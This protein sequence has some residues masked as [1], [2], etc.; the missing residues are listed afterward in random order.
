MM[1][2]IGPYGDAYRFI[3]NVHN[4]FRPIE[5]SPELHL[6]PLTKVKTCFVRVDKVA[7]VQLTRAYRDC[8]GGM[9][10][11]LR[12]NEIISYDAWKTR[13]ALDLGPS[14]QTDG[15]Q[16]SLQWLKRGDMIVDMEDRIPANGARLI[17]A[18]FT[19]ATC[20]LFDKRAAY[21]SEGESP[22]VFSIDPRQYNHWCIS[23][24]N[25]QYVDPRDEA[26]QIINRTR[27]HYNHKIGLNK[28][29][30]WEMWVKELD[31]R[32]EEALDIMS[33][34]S[35]KGTH[36][37][38]FDEQYR[39]N[40][41]VFLVLLGLYASRAAAKQRFLIYKKKQRFRATIINDA[42]RKMEERAGK[43]DFVVAYGNGGFPV[44]L[45]GMIGSGGCHRSL[46]ILL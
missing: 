40:K 18:S 1:G 27:G 21:K 15:V 46:M 4:R 17:D 10:D 32:Y 45:K 6:V 35:L 20:G 29:Q 37:L 31:D 24:Y 42:V 28:Y 19:G 16:I 12:I 9:R 25:P 30:E 13:K 14:F 41:E 34:N 39:A 7:L 2:V 33:K 36:Y 5:Y 38:N 11:P 44:S 43:K 23:H 22:V 8:L 3:A 26:E